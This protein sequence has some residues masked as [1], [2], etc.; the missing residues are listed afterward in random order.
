MYIHAVGHP[1]YQL[2]K[3][4]KGLTPGGEPHSP[5][6]LTMYPH[7][8]RVSQ[9]SGEPPGWG[10]PP[11]SSAPASRALSMGVLAFSEPRDV[12]TSRLEKGQDLAKNDFQ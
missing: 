7:L 10:G 3:Q 6:Q 1:R 9:E 4:H 12:G 2:R 11:P 5:P 8:G